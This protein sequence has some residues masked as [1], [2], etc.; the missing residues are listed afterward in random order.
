MSDTP[1]TDELERVNDFTKHRDLQELIDF[2][3]ELERELNRLDPG[4]HSCSD[5]CQRPLCVARRELFASQAR[6]RRLR[7]ALEAML[8]E[9]GSDTRWPTGETRHE[10]KQVLADARAALSSPVAEQKHPDSERLDWCDANPFRVPFQ[11]WNAPADFKF[12]IREAI[13]A[14]R[15]KERAP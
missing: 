5:S 1:R 2:A 6:E 9:F 3:R 10:A 14:L 8:E 4:V 11:S 15:A 12:N 13:D 7:E